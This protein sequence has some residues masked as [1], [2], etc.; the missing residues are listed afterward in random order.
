MEFT[1]TTAGVD[2]I[3][4]P[5]PAMTLDASGNLGIGTTS[6]TAKLHVNNTAGTIGLRIDAADNPIFAARYS[7]NA[8]GPVIFF[9]KS[10]NATVGSQTVVQNG[11]QLGVLVARGSDGTNFV[12]GASI[13]FAVDGTPGT[14]DMPGRIVFGTSPDGSTSITERARFNSTGAFVFAG[15]TTTANG[16]GITFPATQSA[17]S[18]ANTLDDYEE[19]TYTVSLTGASGGTLSLGTNTTG[20]YVKVGRMVTVGGEVNITGTGTAS[21]PY[22]HITIPFNA[23][24]LTQAAERSAGSV[25][26]VIGAGAWTPQATGL[27]PGSPGMVVEQAP[28]VFTTNSTVRFQFSYVAEN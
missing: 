13:T 7:A 1:Q 18:N 6:P 17:S 26:T 28:S 8:D 4:E 22:Y 11:D 21:G 16:I 15:G 20:W 5:P 25:S 27:Q 9:A 2:P 24:D 3:T 19:G 14:N 23:A 10:R 12:D